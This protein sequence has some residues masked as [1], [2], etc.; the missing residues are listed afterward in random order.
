MIKLIG[1]NVPAIGARPYILF[2]AALL[3]SIVYAAAVE[4]FI[5]PRF[6]QLR[7]KFRPGPRTDR[8]RQS[9]ASS[10]ANEHDRTHDR[11]APG[12]PLPASAMGD[13]RT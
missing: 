4:R 13:N 2:P 5:E 8:R 7:R 3:I 12:N 9:G 11:A 1:E 10:L 6:K